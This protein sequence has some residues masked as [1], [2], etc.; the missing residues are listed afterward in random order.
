MWSG[1]VPDPFAMPF[2]HFVIIVQY[3]NRKIKSNSGFHVAVPCPC[4]TGPNA[5]GISVSHVGTR[6][7]NCLP[8]PPLAWS[9]GP[10][11]FHSDRRK[12]KNAYLVNRAVHALRRA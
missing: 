4:G 12:S 1:N 9:F 10:C 3:K 5:A 11:D 6:V 8:E 2:V 7:E